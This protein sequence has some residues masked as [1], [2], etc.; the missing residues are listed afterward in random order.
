[1]QNL[2]KGY[3]F[4]HIDKFWKGH[5]KLR[6][7]QFFLKT[8]VEQNELNISP[9]LKVVLIFNKNENDIQNFKE[10]WLFLVFGIYGIFCQG[11]TT[12]GKCN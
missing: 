8:F 12:R 4:G 11:Q 9:D 5:D 2:K 10:I 3:V 7:T 1:M 6:K